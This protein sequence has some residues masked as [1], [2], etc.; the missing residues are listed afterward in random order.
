MPNEKDSPEPRRDWAREEKLFELETD[1]R[2]EAQWEAELDEHIAVINEW[3]DDQYRRKYEPGQSQP[4]FEALLACQIERV[5]AP[6]WLIDALK[7]EIELALK[8]PIAWEQLKAAAQAAN[9]ERKRLAHKN[10]E[11]FWQEGSAILELNP[12][13]GSED[14]LAELISRRAKGS[15]HEAAPRTIRRHIKGILA[16]RSKHGQA[17]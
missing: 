9:E 17:D 10:R 5:P 11:W 1:A 6:T 4:C 3:L 7:K 8:R 2:R 13:L 16:K 12:T 15:E 14:R